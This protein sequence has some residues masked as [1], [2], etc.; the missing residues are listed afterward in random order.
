MEF[1]LRKITSDRLELVLSGLPLDIRNYPEE[2]HDTLMNIMAHCCLNGPV[3]VNK[4]TNFP[5]G[6]VG[7]IN[8]LLPQGGR[9]SNKNWAVFCRPFAVEIKNRFPQIADSCQQVSLKGDLWPL[10]DK[11]VAKWRSSKAA[12]I[13]RS[14]LKKTRFINIIKAYN[15]G[16][17]CIDNIEDYIKMSMKLATGKVE[18]EKGIFPTSYTEMFVLVVREFEGYKLKVDDRSF[19]LTETEKHWIHVLQQENEKKGIILPMRNKHNIDEKIRKREK[20]KAAKMVLEKGQKM[21]MSAFYFEVA[22]GIIASMMLGEDLHD[23][24]VASICSLVCL[25]SKKRC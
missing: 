5:G 1:L 6:L 7:S 19:E 12:A 18:I 10:W 11:P 9:I 2:V 4:S 13:H 15:Y 16:A 22:K 14:I 24:Y 25:V 21:L 17:H 23:S 8:S 20:K 3:G